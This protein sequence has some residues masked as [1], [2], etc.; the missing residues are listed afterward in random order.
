MNEENEMFYASKLFQ[1]QLAGKSITEK[2]RAFLKKLE[3]K[4]EAKK[5]LT[6]ARILQAMI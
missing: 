5:E 2:D 3:D 6:I 1:D 4:Y